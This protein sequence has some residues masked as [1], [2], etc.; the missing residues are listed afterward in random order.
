M[1]PR[2]LENRIVRLHYVEHWR[3]T[4]IA[5]AVGVHHGTVRRVLRSRGVELGELTR[6]PSIADPYRAFI[7]ETLK[8]Y[9]KLPAS[10]LYEMIKERGYPGAA[11]HF[12]S[13]VAQHRPR[14]SA[15]AYVRRTT[16]PGEE[17]QVDWGHFGT[18]EV[19][20]GRRSLYAFVV[21]LSHSR[22]VFLRFFLDMKM[23]TFL[24]AHALAF[25][26]FGGVPRV[27]LYDNLKSVVLDR[28]GD[29]IRFNPQLMDFATHHHCVPRACSVARGNE[30]G[31]VER[32]IRYIRSS[33]I[34]ARSW[35]GLDDLNEQAGRWCAEVA[36]RRRWVEDRTLSVG[37]AFDEERPRLLPLPEAP[38]ATE[39]RLSVSIGKVPY[40]RFDGN[41]Y[42]VPHDRVCRRLT[43]LASPT[44]V[45][46]LDGAEV[47]AEHGRRWG[48]GQTI[49]DPAHLDGLVEAKRTARRHKGLDRLA[50][51]VPSCRALLHAAAEYGHNLGAVVGALLR[52]LDHYGADVVEAAV[53]EA[54]AAGVAHAA[55]VRQ[56]VEQRVTA[57]PPTLGVRLPEALQ[58][59]DVVVRPH[60][61]G[62]YDPAGGA[63]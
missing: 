24:H 8:Q 62:D 25:A 28:Q 37:E 50:E 14:K 31:R 36:D 60:S 38:Y 18:L 11:D 1:I 16:L 32:G 34:P 45:R 51:S 7:E 44:R 39:D 54:L 48:R 46:L 4:T 58:A 6:R 15:E 42:S 27:L 35:A 22:H 55:G 13:I 2:D 29:I 21:V 3:I 33:F 59:K 53:V 10:R 57:E 12:R 20:G 19:P 56:I 23:G 26:D 30:K 9:P 61:L 41:D 17:G 63:P 43:A 49:E 47:V 40:A 52:L 5:R